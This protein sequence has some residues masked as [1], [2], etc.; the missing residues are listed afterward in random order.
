[1]SMQKLFKKNP[2][3]TPFIIFALIC[4]LVLSLE[5]FSIIHSNNK[6]TK[7]A[8]YQEKLEL[9]LNDFELQMDN[10]VSLTFHFSL[11]NTYKYSVISKTKYN[12]I[13]LLKDFEKY[14]YSSPLTENFSLYYGSNSIFHVSGNLINLEVY[15]NALSITDS[16]R[17]N[18]I[19]ILHSVVES[20]DSEPLILSTTE[21]I[22]LLIPFQTDTG[23]KKHTAL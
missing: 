18:I 2:F 19:S 6:A 4:V 9:L 23:N 13:L 17:D 8:Y 20:T 16:E 3:L 22:F 5:F 1:M 12:E 7:E 11:D 14:K 21:N 10:L 15:L